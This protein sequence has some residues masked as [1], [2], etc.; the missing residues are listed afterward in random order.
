[1]VTAK[2]TRA[3]LSRRADDGTENFFWRGAE[4]PAAVSAFAGEFDVENEHLR[5]GRSTQY[6]RSV[7]T[8]AHREYRKHA[9]RTQWVCARCTSIA[10][11]E[12]R[13]FDSRSSRRIA[14]AA[15]KAHDNERS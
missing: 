11:D 8:V 13:G 3:P 10:E 4:N 14:V 2:T 5:C 7:R 15:T 12:M 9:Y 6:P 1:M